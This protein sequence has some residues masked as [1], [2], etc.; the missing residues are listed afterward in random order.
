MTRLKFYAIALFSLVS[1]TAIMAQSGEEKIF[2]DLNIG[3]WQ[4][5]LPW[6]SARAVTGSDSKIYYATPW[7]VVEIDKTD[8]SPKFLYKT[9]GFNDV[10]IKLVRFNKSANVLFVGY[11]DAN[12]DLYYPANGSVVNL[13]FIL[14]NTVLSGDKTLKT[15]FFDNE[16][17]YLGT[18]FG[19][20]KLDMTS[21]E[22]DFT[23]F[24]G[25]PVR[26]FAVYENSYYMG[27]EDGL[28]RVAI[29]DDNPAD[30]SRWKMLGTQEGFVPGEPVNALA[31]FGEFLFL[32]SEGSG[33]LRY[34]GSDAPVVLDDPDGLQVSLLTTEGTGLVSAWKNSDGVGR[35]MYQEA[36]GAYY[37]VQGPCD[38]RRPLDVVEDGT[39]KFWFADEYDQFRYFDAATGQCDFFVYDSPYSHHVAEIAVRG[40]KVFVA[41]LGADP[42][43]NPQNSKYGL[44]IRDENGEWRRISGDSNPELKADNCDQDWWRV[45]PHPT[46][47][48]V[49]VGSFSTGLVE[50]KD[51]GTAT[52]CYNKN[53][54]ILQNAGEAGEGRTAIGGMAFDKDD[55]L[56]ICNYSAASPI[57]VL[58]PDGTFLHYDVPGTGNFKQVVIDKN[59]YKW[60][61]S[62]FTGGLSV[63]DSGD[64]LADLSDDQYKVI[65][66]SNSVLATSE[67]SCAEVDLDGDVWVGTKE[68]LYSFE[69][70]SA[71]FNDEN[72]CKGTRQIVNVDGF[73]GYLLQDENIKSIAIDGANRKWVGTTNGI[74]VQSADGRTTIARYDASNSPLPSSI[75]ED[76]AINQQSGEVWI[77]TSSGIVSVR[78]D[79][80]LGGAINTNKPYAYPN[81]VRPDYDGPIAIYGLARDANVKITDIAG[82]LVY[83]GTANGGQAIWNGR[84]YLGRRAASGVYLVYATSSTSFESPDAV[85]TKVVVIN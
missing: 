3:E 79:A 56:W 21:A 52:K 80:T 47:D 10:G 4:Q 23:V 14:K 5:H 73:N 42:N 58:K 71:I 11:T 66:V 15:V 76:I 57:A 8:R 31:V 60:F 44:Y 33:L 24:T 36:S 85:V 20:I 37:E 40:N 35:V 68:G 41:T 16:F 30:F 7:S 61:V 82:H 49:Y 75:I 83:E 64:D 18:G 54:S 46:E 9:E 48:K 81:P 84:D 53:N 19:A 78:S 55:N 72:P 32:G 45:T 2:P 34:N 69:C 59:G 50:M 43:L 67:V 62:A 25:L 13:P 12:I 74:F 27:T 22:V 77:G 65:N 70:T 38:A 63:F 26:S 51:D 17:A 1:L 29:D 6:Q 28:F 39:R